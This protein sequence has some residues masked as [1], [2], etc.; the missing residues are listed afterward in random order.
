MLKGSLKEGVE[1]KNKNSG[2]LNSQPSHLPFWV[3]KG[4]CSKLFSNLQLRA[5]LPAAKASRSLLC[6]LGKD[7]AIQRNG[8]THTGR[9]SCKIHGKTAETERAPQ[10]PSSFVTRAAV[11]TVGWGDSRDRLGSSWYVSVCWVWAAAGWAAQTKG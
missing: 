10:G 2:I 6:V 5:T 1:A 7:R 3:E 4:P 11:G 8:H 9:F